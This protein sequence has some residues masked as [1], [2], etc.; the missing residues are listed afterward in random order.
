MAAPQSSSLYVGDLNGDVTEANLFDVFREIGPVLSIRVC[1]DAVTRRSLGYAYVNYQSHTDAQRA[2]ADLN[3]CKIKS[4]SCRIMWC[5]RD[6]SMRKSG[7]GNI[8]VKNL[9][10]DIDNKTLH[11]TFQPFGNILSC[12]VVTDSEGRSR[13]FGFVHFE[14]TESAD[15][16]VKK[17]NRMLLNGTQ[18][19]VGKFER[20]DKKIRDLEQTFTNTY[21]K[22][23]RR[24]ATDADVTKY[25]STFGE[26][27]SHLVRRDAEGKS[28]GFAFVAFKEHTAAAKAVQETNGNGSTD[29]SADGRPLYCSRHQRKSEREHLRRQAQ[30][31][32]AAQYAKYAN[33]YVKN[34]DD[35]VT[36]ATLRE[37]FS[38]FGEIISARVMQDRDTKVSKGFGFVCFRDPE[39]AN[40]AVGAMN[41]RIF[42]GKPLYVALAQRKDQRRAQ[43]ELYYR[44][45]RNPFTGG[46]TGPSSQGPQ[47]HLQQGMYGGY[48]PS[49]GGMRGKG[50]ASRGG[51]KGGAAAPYAGK[52]TTAVMPMAPMPMGM[53]PMG[54]MARQ[55]MP[56][57][58]QAPPRQPAAGLSG[59]DPKRLSTMSQDQAKNY[60]GEKLFARIQ[61]KDREN[62]AKI[63][64]MLLEMDNAE[65]INLLDSPLMLDS[66][67]Q[68]AIQVLHDHSQN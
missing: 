28:M 24:D 60:L 9:A 48:G 45:G 36:T 23:I 57:M 16:A 21:V 20:K 47:G 31:E 6:P 40:K 10:G 50:G 67:V 34:L 7:A 29:L 63:T 61:E 25:F 66:K 35:T 52:G 22:H 44:S 5:R 12:K 56:A 59:V 43:L 62:A 39:A 64:G 55:Q 32:R 38:E 17:V 13:N 37:S 42:C 53:M 15:E 18:V 26:I 3:F 41:G 49:R 2:L 4:R 14:R 1:R 19:Y 54:P 8:F 11:D 27:S 33:L 46:T 51:L 65:I 30:R 58:P 68:E